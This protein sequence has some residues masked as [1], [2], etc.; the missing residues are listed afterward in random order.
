MKKAACCLMVGL[1]AAAAA[2]Q[3]PAAPATQQ[4]PP[5]ASL[6]IAGSLKIQHANIRRNLSASAEKM[7]DADF[8]FKP[9]GVVPEM[10]TFGQIIAHLANANN[11]TCA[12]LKGATAPSRLDD[13]LTQTKAE[14][15]KALS[16]ALTL[17]D[18]VYDAA[19][20]TT[21]NEMIKVPGPNDTQVERARGNALISNI[22]HNNEHYG[23]LV[24]YFRAKGLVP[25]SSEG[26]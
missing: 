25:P 21:I 12:R 19:T 23:N 3:Q 26:R 1:C 11:T 7:P 10:R 16:D 14:L 4:T 20:S 2:A 13:K 17:C 18:S 5:P 8:H 24:T 6:D 22:A 15:V 9:Q